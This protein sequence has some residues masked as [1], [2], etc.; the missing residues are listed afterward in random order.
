[1]NDIDIRREL[2]KTYLSRYIEDNNSKIIEELGLCQGSNKI[3]IAI[4]NNS[5][6]GW[7]IKSEQDTLNRLPSQ[8]DMYN[9]IFDY[10]YIIT[11]EKHLKKINKIIPDFWGVI[12]VHQNGSDIK[13][14]IIRKA[15]KNLLVESRYLVQLLW[16]NEAIEI[17]EKNGLINGLRSKPKT[18]LWG[19]IS[20]SLSLRQ[21][22]EYVREY[23]KKREKWRVID[24][25]PVLNDD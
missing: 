6:I 17:L 20:D 21:I 7:E 10:L 18:I 15:S 22:N 13:T 14:I 1:M 3:D 4:I 11:N 19:K 9:R 12:G 8:V 23:L 2:K 25:Q 5:L 24:L 16:K